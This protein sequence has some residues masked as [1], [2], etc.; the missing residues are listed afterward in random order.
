MIK[1]AS[2]RFPTAQVYYVGFDPF[3]QRTS[4]DGF[5]LTLKMAHR[6][7]RRTGACVQ[8]IP[9]EPALSL[10]RYANELGKV[11]LLLFSANVDLESHPHMWLFVPR[12]LHDQTLVYL[13]RP[14]ADGRPMIRRLERPELNALVAANTSRR[15]A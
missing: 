2:F 12:M 5:G 9:G 13:E 6:L 8:L 7:F 1:A 11:D 10:V 3:E 4:R 15:A 14:L